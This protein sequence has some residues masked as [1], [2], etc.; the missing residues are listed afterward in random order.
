M[1]FNVGCGEARLALQLLP[2]GL[3]L[4]FPHQVSDAPTGHLAEPG[5]EGANGRVVVEFRQILRNGNE[6]LLDDVLAVSVVQTGTASQA[7]NH[8]PVEV[9]ELLPT[10]LIVEVFEA[11]EEALASREVFVAFRVHPKKKS[12]TTDAHG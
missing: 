1:R 6:R 9:E 11:L 10:P 7:V 12:L 5:F 2:V 8:F 4:P 3:I